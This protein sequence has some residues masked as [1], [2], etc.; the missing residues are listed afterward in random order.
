MAKFLGII[1]LLIASMKCLESANILV[2]FHMPAYSHFVLGESLVKGLAQ[3]GHNVT[4]ISAF[5]QKEK[6]Y[7]HITVVY[8]AYKQG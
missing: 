4:L 5:P 1:F 3:K 6:S 2:I 8:E 7:R